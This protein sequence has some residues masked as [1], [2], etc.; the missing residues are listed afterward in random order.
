MPRLLPPLLLLL[1]LLAP[2]ALRAAEGN[3]GA[4]LPPNGV[5]E[6]PLPFPRALLDDLS[7]ADPKVRLAALQAMKPFPEVVSVPRLLKLAEADPVAEVRG[8][9]VGALWNRGDR[10]AARILEVLV[11]IDPDPEVKMAAAG[12]LGTVGLKTSTPFL[13]RAMEANSQNHALLARCLRSVGELK[14]SAAAASILPYLGRNWPTLVRGNAANALGLLGSE[15]GAPPLLET[16]EKDPDPTVRAQAAEALGALRLPSTEEA[17]GRALLFDTAPEVRYRAATALADF[18]HGDD[19]RQAFLKGIRDQDRRVRYT[20]MVGLS[21][22]AR[23]E[24]VTDIA[25]L[26]S[27]AAAS[28]REMAFETLRR[29]GAQMERIED[30][31]RL[32]Q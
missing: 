6:E 23:R 20:S 10:R 4:T 29:L 25:E 12:A 18:G 24:D 22:R 16:L 28:I 21:T 2:G 1:L 13:V 30:H 7:S 9:A 17:L 14:D 3:A 5:K 11:N 26:L 19:V 8:E 27:D 32:V 31:Y 15:K